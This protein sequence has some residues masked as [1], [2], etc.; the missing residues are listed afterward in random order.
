MPRKFL[1]RYIKDESVEDLEFRRDLA[2]KKFKKEINLLR[3]RSDKQHFA[4]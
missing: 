1:P 4:K 3:K 2:V